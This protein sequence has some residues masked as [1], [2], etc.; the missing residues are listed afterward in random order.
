M[1]KKT[2]AL[3]GMHPE[4]IKSLEKL[5]HRLRANRIAQG[6]TV[7]QMANRLFCSPNTY[8]A[9]EAGKPTS[10]VGIIASALW[11]FEQIDTLDTVAPIPIGAI[12]IQRV[13]KPNKMVGESLISEEE[14]DF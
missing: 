13:R 1:P 3:V 2:N 8:R 6:W 12:A 11:L 9:M 4:A 10:S 14:R 5:G 7:Q